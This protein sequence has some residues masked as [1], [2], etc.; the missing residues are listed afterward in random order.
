VVVLATL[1]ANRGRLTVGTYNP[2]TGRWQMITPDLPT[3]HPPRF[4]A[5]AATDNRVILWSGWA[6]E[7]PPNPT[8]GIDVL[9]FA[10]DQS[11]LVGP[12]H[13]VTGKWPQGLVVS[14][15]VYTGDSILLPPN[16]Q[17]CSICLTVAHKYN[18]YFVNPV[19][20]HRTATVPGGPL[21][22]DV[23]DFIW[24]GRTVIAVANGRGNPLPFK[25]TNL[26]DYDPGTRTWRS[27]AAAP[28]A[29]Q[30]NSMPVWTGHEL[31]VV[32][33]QGATLALHR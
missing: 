9:A 14:N 32:T 2:V 30:T 6:V 22:Q 23:A 20:L 33:D 21:D 3:G 27:L 16:R 29:D 31:L 25:L 8:V 17:W 1:D 12:W 11:S 5:M 15:P 13:N 26:A 4:V 19:T 18:G 28:R 10:D 24:T 7:G